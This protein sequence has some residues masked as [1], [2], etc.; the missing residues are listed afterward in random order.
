MKS[1]LG[2][3]LVLAAGGMLLAAD[4]LPQ[5]AQEGVLRK[6]CDLAKVEK[7]DYCP[8]C[9]IFAIPSE[10]GAGEEAGK[11]AEEKG[12][13]AKCKSQLEKVD[14]CLKSAF[15]CKMHGEREILHSERCCPP[16][17]KDCCVETV[18]PSLVIFRCDTC[19]RWARVA[20][21]I[22][23]RNNCTGRA[24]RTC[25]QSGLFPHGGVEPRTNE[26]SG[27]APHRRDQK[28]SDPNREVPR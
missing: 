26:R 1:R 12:T 3:I 18:L 22:Q 19:S 21:D 2:P 4:G 15:P 7:R 13:C 10:S 9:R 20:A 25:E 5:E 28:E 14:T 8:G 27:E 23:H 17:V 16:S 24:V 6:P 11:G